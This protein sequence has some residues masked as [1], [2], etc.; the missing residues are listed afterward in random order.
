MSTLP[1]DHTTAP[2]PDNRPTRLDVD[3]LLLGSVALTAKVRRDVIDA[4]ESADL[5][6]GGKMSSPTDALGRL[7]ITGVDRAIARFEESVR[8]EVKSHLLAVG[9]LTPPTDL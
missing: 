8:I 6:N 2:A 9:A 3:A 5:L 1:Y 4:L 7:S